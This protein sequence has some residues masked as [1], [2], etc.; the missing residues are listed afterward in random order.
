MGVPSDVQPAPGSVAPGQLFI[1]AQTKMGWLGVPTSIDAS[2]S[3]LFS[4]IIGLLEED[5]ANSVAD[6]AYTDGQIA[7]RAPTVHTHAIADVT[8]LQAALDTQANGL[9][10]GCIVIWSGIIGDIPGGWAICNGQ[11]GTP[12][13]RERVIRGAGGNMATLSTGGATTRTVNSGLAGAHNHGGV[14]GATTLTT[15]QIP[16]HTHPLTDP[17][18]N[19]TGTALSAGSHT[20]VIGMN[21]NDGNGTTPQSAN[22]GTATNAATDAGG[23]HTHTL[24]IASNDTGITIGANTG[25]GGSHTHTIASQ[26]DHQH[27]VSVD[28]QDPYIVLAYIMKV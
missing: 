18:H 6:R 3:V 15:A 26:A 8:G 27:S 22:G 10:D 5:T 14:S 28:V 21:G 1:D 20:H 11:N 24:S 7:T 2:Q 19:H 4:D 25:G 17:G 9:P 23:A 13:T 12:D 16:A